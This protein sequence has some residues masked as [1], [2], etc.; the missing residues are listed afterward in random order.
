MICDRVQTTTFAY[1]IEEIS[2]GHI[3]FFYWK[4]VY[5]QRADVQIILMQ[6]LNAF[7]PDL[8]VPEVHPQ[9][10]LNISLR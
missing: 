10:D 1:A 6:L 8:R 2:D 4:N 7:E 3:V 9:S 5:L